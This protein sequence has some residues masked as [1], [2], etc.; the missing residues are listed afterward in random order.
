MF[1]NTVCVSPT[2][3]FII[4][5]QK[6]LLFKNRIIF[7][8]GFKHPGNFKQHMAT[9]LRSGK[10]PPLGEKRPAD[11]NNKKPLGTTSKMLKVDSIIICA[12]CNQEFPNEDSLQDHISEHHVRE[13]VFRSKW[14]KLL[15]T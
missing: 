15:I 12:L 14:I 7:K 1:V 3:Y 13:F 4:R 10:L 9:H 5:F 2:Y 6:K 8:G 11:E